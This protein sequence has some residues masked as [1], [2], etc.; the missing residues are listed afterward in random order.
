M[1]LFFAVG[2]T[3]PRLFG[4]ADRNEGLR[5]GP[6]WALSIEVRSWVPG[7]PGPGDKSEGLETL[8]IKREVLWGRVGP[9]PSNRSVV[10]VV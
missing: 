9:G 6:E 3:T 1:A 8:I 2:L 10:D 4:L 7:G 5:A